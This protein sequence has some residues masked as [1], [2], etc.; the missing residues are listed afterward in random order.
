MNDS[1]VGLFILEICQA[2]ALPYCPRW[3]F[4]ILVWFTRG[5]TV[6]STQLADP[7]L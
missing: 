6:K 7:L 1:V 3:H 4:Q 2:F 5:P